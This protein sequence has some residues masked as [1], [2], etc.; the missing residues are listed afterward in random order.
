MKVPSRYGVHPASDETCDCRRPFEAPRDTG[1]ALSQEHA[2]EAESSSRAL[3]PHRQILPDQTAPCVATT[4]GLIVSGSPAP[5]HN[6]KMRRDSVPR[7]HGKLATDDTHWQDYLDERNS[8]AS[9]APREGAP[10]AASRKRSAA[11]LR[12]SAARRDNRTRLAQ[13]LGGGSSG[14]GTSRANVT[15]TDCASFTP[16]G[17]IQQ[18]PPQ[19]RERIRIEAEV[20]GGGVT[21]TITELKRSIIRI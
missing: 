6:R 3:V 7:A 21:G 19:H 4:H 20:T 1:L 15:G 12:T 5:L 14:Q 10:R 13:L 18:P 8:V 17:A 11:E 2:Q 16:D 9:Q